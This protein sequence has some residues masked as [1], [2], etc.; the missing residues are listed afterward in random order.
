[1]VGTTNTKTVTLEE[2]EKVKKALVAAELKI[3]TLPQL[4]SLTGLPNNALFQDRLS[5]GMARA[6]RSQRTLAVIYLDIDYTKLI[7]AK[8]GASGKNALTCDFAERFKAAI[9]ETDTLSRVGFDRFAVLMEEVK[10]PKIV[11][12][13]VSKIIASVDEGFLIKGD[14]ITV[15]TSIGVA[16][17]DGADMLQADVLLAAENA[18][19]KAK[20]AGRSTFEFAS[21]LVGNK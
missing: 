5:Q 19:F 10:S 17:Y 21:N 15:S 14:E 20:A 11:K 9:R 1:M 13:I 16:F 12:T 18:L 6:R 2:H 3:T 4:D 8:L 7:L